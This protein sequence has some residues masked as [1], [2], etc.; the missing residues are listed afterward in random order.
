MEDEDLYNNQDGEEED[1]EEDVVTMKQMIEEMDDN[2]FAI[3]EAF[4]IEHF[5]QCTYQK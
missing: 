4:R 5:A 1:N 3:L 2:H